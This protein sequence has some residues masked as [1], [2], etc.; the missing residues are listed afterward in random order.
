[1][2]SGTG[3]TQPREYNWRATWQKSSGSCLENRDYGRRDQSRW[4]RGTLYPQK[5]AITSPTSGG[6]SVVIVRSR[7]QTMEF[8]WEEPKCNI[9]RSYKYLTSSVLA[10]S[11][12]AYGSSREGSV[13]SFNW[14]VNRNVSLNLSDIPLWR[15]VNIHSVSLEVFHAE[16]GRRTWF[17]ENLTV[18]GRCLNRSHDRKDGHNNS[19]Q[20][21]QTLLVLMEVL[22]GSM[23]YGTSC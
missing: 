10:S 18:N 21:A 17:K 6:R 7:N 11:T 23:E 1:V 9:F 3:S 5:L 12:S 20:S 19:L 15:T 4:P 8:L 16:R 13:V 22:A 14:N 2:G